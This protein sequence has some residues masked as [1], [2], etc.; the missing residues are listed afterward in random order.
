MKLLI[1]EEIA[2][3]EVQLL[4][5]ANDK[6]KCF[7]YFLNGNPVEF[8]LPNHHSEIDKVC[9]KAFSKNHLSDVTNIVERYRQMN[10]GRG[11]HFTSN[12]MNI[13]AFALCTESVKEVE[14]K[15]YWHNHG[16]FEQF[17]ITQIFSDFPPPNNEPKT[18]IDKL[19]NVV[20]VKKEIENSTKLMISLI[21]KCTEL[22]EFF[23]IQKSFQKVC[24]IH[25]NLEIEKKYEVLSKSFNNIKKKKTRFV[26]FIMITIIIA[27]AFGIRQLFVQKWD[28]WKIEP[29]L[30]VL[31][32]VVLFL[33]PLIEK[34]LNINLGTEKILDGLNDLLFRLFFPNWRKIQQVI[35]SEN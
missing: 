35:E 17:I 9:F 31:G 10:I 25:P 24:E 14:L 28:E 16:L 5:K 34:A 15:T 1:S 30:A 6:E 27:I 32:G 2:Q 18:E 3:K 19:I 11:I 12:L 21:G 33:I 23:V 7:Y 20:F 4:A 29:N 13:C 22:T 26:H 8:Q